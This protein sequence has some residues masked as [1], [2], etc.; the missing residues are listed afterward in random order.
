MPSGWSG[1]VTNTL[2]VMVNDYYFK[3][4]VRNTRN[5]RKEKTPCLSEVFDVEKFDC[6]L[7]FESIPKARKYLDSLDGKHDRGEFSIG[8]NILN[9]RGQIIEERK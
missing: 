4:K 2:G 9:E 3:G 8:K 5:T 1:F 7:K 6:Y